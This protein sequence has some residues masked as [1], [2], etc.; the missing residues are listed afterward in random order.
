MRVRAGNTRRFRGCGHVLLPVQVVGHV[1][2]GVSHVARQFD[3][4]LRRGCVDLVVAALM[5]SRRALYRQSVHGDALGRQFAYAAHRALKI[6]YVL[7][8]QCGDQVHVYVI[9]AHAARQCVGVQRVARGVTAA[10]DLERA[11]AQRLGIDRYAGYAQ[12]EQ[13]LEFGAVDGVGATGFAG[14]LNR[15][16]GI[17]AVPRL[18]RV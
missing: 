10:D 3:H 7:A 6:G 8:G 4:A 12:V 2:G 17:R 11:V 13:R 15:V 1:P 5:Q 18:S 16:G 14:P 9:K